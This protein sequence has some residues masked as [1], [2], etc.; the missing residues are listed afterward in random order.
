MKKVISVLLIIIVIFFLIIKFF[1]N[2]LDYSGPDKVI[3]SNNFTPNSVKVYFINLD[4]SLQR[5]ISVTSEIEKL[6]YSFERI[7]AVYGKN[8]GKDLKHKYVNKEKFKMLMHRSIDPGTLGCFLSH[9]KVWKAF[10]ESKYNFAVICEDDV[11][12]DPGQ[13]KTIIQGLINHKDKWDLVNI[14]I[15]HNGNPEK[16]IKIADPDF[17]LV[18]FRSRVSNTS[19]YILNR[20][21]AVKLLS[22]AFPII[23]PVDHFFIRFWELDIIFR[24]V[25]PVITHQGFAD[26]EI[27]RQ[28]KKN[29]KPTLINQISSV[30]FQISTSTAIFVYSL[31]EKN[32]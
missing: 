10:L 23:M 15:R 12:F 1:M 5:R 19:C 6:G 25:I 11:K 28:I 32:R 20:H 2:V 26:S 8:I 17:Y 22:K 21:A 7:S 16:I 24:G 30:L 27:K 31:I 13:L 9:V 18:K 3:E 29:K 14:D 4:S